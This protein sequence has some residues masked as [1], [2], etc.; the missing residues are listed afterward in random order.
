MS[1]LYVFYLLDMKETKVWELLY[2]LK[3][4]MEV[5]IMEEEKENVVTQTAEEQTEKTEGAVTR[6]CE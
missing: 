5:L 6:N 2:Y 3:I 1:F 4:K